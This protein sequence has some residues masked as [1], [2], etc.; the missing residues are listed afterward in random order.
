MKLRYIT[1]GRQVGQFLIA[2]T[3]M[4]GGMDAKVGRF[5][6]QPLGIIETITCNPPFSQSHIGYWPFE[7]E[8]GTHDDLLNEPVMG[9]CGLGEGI[10]TAIVTEMEQIK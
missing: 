2:E 8:G 3:L 7:F 10:V 1:V 6:R 4:T 5:G 9:A